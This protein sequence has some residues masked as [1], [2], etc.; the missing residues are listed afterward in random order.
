M[1]TDPAK[2]KP[3]TTTRS[4]SKASTR[5]IQQVEQLIASLDDQ[6]RWVQTGRMKYHGDDDP[7]RKVI[8]CRTFCRNIRVLSA[9]L[10]TK[11][12]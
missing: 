6:G 8:D 10:A 4:R 2:L 5:M 9:Y 3:T 12:R 1:A 7:T 11:P